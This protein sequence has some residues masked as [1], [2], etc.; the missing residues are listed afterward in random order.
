M[1]IARMSLDN[2]QNQ[3]QRNDKM[4]EPISGAAAGAVG[5]KLIGGI[6]GLLAGV[7]AIAAGF[8]SIVVFCMM[9][10]RDGREWAVGLICTSMGAFG[11]GAALIQYLEIQHWAETQFG[12]MGMLGL[13]FTCGLPA[14]AIV[15]WFFN[16]IMKN[17]DSDIASVVRD[18]KGLQ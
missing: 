9:R 18:F 8:A 14:W 1:I 4:S 6:P 11:G 15:R 16:Y 5:W 2:F 7:A 10:P 12:L 3:R 17:K 13:M